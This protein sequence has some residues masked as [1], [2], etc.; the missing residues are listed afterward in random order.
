MKSLLSR[1]S[2]LRNSLFSAAALGASRFL[3]AP[4]LLAAAEPGRKLNCAVIGTGGRGMS[5]L[6]W[7]ANQSK[8]NLVAIVDADEK[9]HAAVRQ[10]MAR[11]EI[12]S[13]RLQ[14]FTD[15][16]VMFDKIGKQL[17]AVVVAT[18]NHQH[19]LPSM[20]AMHLGKGVYCEKP[21]THDIAESR[22]MRKMAAKSKAPTQ[23]GN[24]GHNEDGYRRLIEFINA[25]V[26]GDII[27]TH[28]WTDRANGGVGPRPPY[29]KVPEGMHWDSWIGPAAY[30]DF[31][32]DIHPHEWHGWFDF[33]NGSLGNMGCH[34][35]DGVFWALEL[36][37]PKTLELLQIRQGSDERFPTGSTL[38]WD[39]PARGY[40][41]P[42][43]VFWYEGLRMDSPA[44][45]SGTLRQAKGD[46]QNLPPLLAELR[47]KY[48]DEVFDSN[49]TLYVGE[50][51][52]L[53]T[54]TYGGQMHLL[55]REKS[56][57]LSRSIPKTLPRP[58][59][60]MSEFLDACREGKRTTSASFDY[61]AR[62][63]EFTLLGNLAQHAGV[64]NIVEWDGA[65]MRVTNQKELNRWVKIPCRKGWSW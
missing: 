45:A 8:D 5:H 51:G 34:V 64:G 38:R 31:H 16:R 42:V 54:G 10:W 28:S 33:G 55:P 24:Q 7:I 29:E 4:A 58:K 52:I 60:V 57:E 27:E 36:E 32:S 65:K 21:L 56:Q 35:L 61:G 40:F 41:P 48:P 14:A 9:R 50:K 63:T 22:A 1:R 46:D 6:E 26:V 12:N 20:L 30:R 3:S 2:F 44:G 23:M 18:P 37:H 13:S 49:G 11:K 62:L 15:Y 59:N 19:T 43:K 17:D 47:Q 53:Y 39:F 25:G